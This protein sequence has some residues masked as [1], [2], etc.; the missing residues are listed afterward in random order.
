MATAVI[1]ENKSH[2]IEYLKIIRLRDKKVF[3]I[4]TEKDGF[5]WL[6]T[7]NKKRVKPLKDVKDLEKRF[8]K[9]IIGVDN[10]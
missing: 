5:K 3:W 6:C 8:R 2:I 9:H 7:K 10:D 1:I 4:A